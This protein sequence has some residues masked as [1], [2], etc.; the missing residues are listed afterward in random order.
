[1]LIVDSSGKISGI[2]RP[3]VHMTGRSPD[4]FV[5]DPSLM[6]LFQLPETTSF[7]LLSQ[8]SIGGTP[9]THETLTPSTPFLAPPT[10]LHL[11]DGETHPITSAIFL[12]EGRREVQVKCVSVNEYGEQVHSLVDAMLQVSP[13]T[14]HPNV[15]RVLVITDLTDLKQRDRALAAVALENQRLISEQR[16]M[17]AFVAAS[18]VAP[19]RT[20]FAAAFSRDSE[21]GIPELRIATDHIRGLLVATSE[22]MNIPLPPGN[23]VFPKPGEEQVAQTPMPSSLHHHHQQLMRPDLTPLLGS[24]LS[25]GGALLDSSS[26]AAAARRSQSL[27]RSRAITPSPAPPPSPEALTHFALDVRL[28]EWLGTKRPEPDPPR[29]VHLTADAVRVLDRLLEILRELPPGTLIRWWSVRQSK[30]AVAT[31]AAPNATPTPHTVAGAGGG[32]GGEIATPHTPPHTPLHDSTTPNTTPAT[33]LSLRICVPSSAQ[34]AVQQLKHLVE[35]FDWSRPAQGAAFSLLLL[36]VAVIKQL[37]SR[38]GGFFSV[39]PNDREIRVRIPCRA[40]TCTP[41]NSPHPAAGAI[42]AI[43][44]TGPSGVEAVGGTVSVHGDAPVAAAV[45]SHQYH[46]SSLPPVAESVAPLPLLSIPARNSNNPFP[47]PVHSEATPP[48]LPPGSTP[49]PPPQQQRADLVGGGAASSGSALPPLGRGLSTAALNTP[50]A[51]AT[52]PTTT[53]TTTAAAVADHGPS[54]TLVEAAA[55]A[56]LL[57]LSPL[58]RLSSAP[59][60]SSVAPVAAAAAAAAVAQPKTAVPATTTTVTTNGSSAAPRPSSTSSSAF[61]LHTE[62]SPACAVLPS[63]PP[64]AERTRLTILVV[65]DNVLVQQVTKRFLMTAG[66]TVHI[67]DNGRDALEKLGLEFNPEGTAATDADGAAAGASAGANGGEAGHAPNPS[68]A[69]LAPPTGDPSFPPPPV[70]VVVMDLLMPICD[71]YEA[72]RQIRRRWSP[73]LLPVVA[74]TANAVADEA[75]RC[76]QA[77]ITAFLNKPVRR[78]QLVAVV[79]NAVGWWPAVEAARAEAAAAAAAAAGAAANNV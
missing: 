25:T 41:R 46:V 35:D 72:T 21:N 9:P 73:E 79:Q 12:A 31:S 56:A 64:P 52:A 18:M 26:A 24:G 75:D 33:Y 54:R 51:S 57:P 22:L 37:L 60:A 71:G 39:L 23:M 76:F 49:P 30:T 67:A 32:N 68:P 14:G 45:A 4:S 19:L 42:S 61:P 70:D 10:P 63:L 20:F 6:S 13:P 62:A 43:T 78:N 55:A 28:G 5:E 48:P 59:S 58:S 47:S 11:E 17:L 2:N 36:Q 15:H 29:C 66:H 7:D 16:S 40:C 34:T 53:A 50:P 3:L 38:I 44:A 74:V 8:T 77:G 65:E 27:A 69:S 1:M